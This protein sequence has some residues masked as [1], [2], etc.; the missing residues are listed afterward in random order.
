MRNIKAYN[1]ILSFALLTALLL[2][3][4]PTAFQK[5]TASI[6]L[7]TQNIS[8]R[9]E[10]ILKKMTLEEK[11]GQIIQADISAVTPEEAKEYNLGSV[12]NGGNSAPGG[13]VTAPARNWIALADEFWHASTD[14]SDGGVG[15]PLL[16]GTDA[17]HG[18]N[19]LQNATIFPHNSG[20]GAT[21]NPAL[22]RE[23]GEITAKEIRATGIDWTFAP[24]L[25]VARDD[26]W[27]RAYES[28]SENP[29]L[30]S[31]Y[32]E[33]MVEGL[34]GQYQEQNFLKDEHVIA[35][36]KHFFADGGTHQGI[37][38][39]DAQGDL[40]EIFNIHAAGYGPAISSQAQTVMASFSSINGEKMHGSKGF[41]T[42]LLRSEMGF[43][44]FVVGDWNGHG[45]VPGCSP[46]D[47]LQALHAGLD[48]FMA[49]DSWKGLYKSL[50][51]HAKSGAMDMKRLDEAVNRILEVKIR[52]GLLDSVPPSERTA[53]NPALLGHKEHRATARQAVR[54]SL[55]LLKNN[56][57][58]LPI[59]GNANILVTGS[60]AH[61]MQQQTGGWTLS[62]Q[63]DSNN[64]DAFETGE[65][66]FEGIQ[67]AAKKFGGNAFLSNDGSYTEKP[68]AAIVI[69]GEQPYAEYRGDR[70]DLV[71][72][73]KDGENLKLLKTLK[74]NG[75]P[76][77]SVF[78]TG[79]PLWVNSHI[80]ASDAF[81]VAWL[82]GT[83]AGGIADV[84]IG[85]EKA[86]PRY[87]F[88]GTLSF[89]WPNVGSGEP[90]NDA[91][92]P[93]TLFP[94]GFGLTYESSTRTAHLQED[95]GV[96]EL[97]DNFDGK[98]IT[99]GDAVAPFA[100]FLGDNSNPNTPVTSQLASSISGS[101]NVKGTDYAAQED[102]RT[103]TWNGKGEGSFSVRVDRAVNLNMLGNPETL[104]INLLARIN[105]QPIGSVYLSV[106]CGEGC[107]S[108]I[109][110][111]PMIKNIESN[112]WQTWHF[113]ISCFD[114]GKLKTDNIET[115]FSIRS[116]GPLSISVH[117]GEFISS[118][119]T[120]TC[121]STSAS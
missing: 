106:G 92:H 61:S 90:L 79:R 74:A 28:Y 1:K 56:N 27:G 30:V 11:I 7:N 82:P 4:Y 17:V 40:K 119:D 76:T 23:I 22:I 91:D 83:E 78:L 52:A 71:F 86:V 88:T 31:I 105:Q 87:N 59:A 39:G 72:E 6:P 120:L 53:T 46:T 118:N 116:T 97:G 96:V 29:A 65:T 42:D 60:G 68:D 24:T 104:A 81:V 80:N 114:L 5:S 98:L 70:S 25:A 21:K 73:F 69:F 43:E 49:P 36:A 63:G 48:M 16:W 102:A 33:A 121:P 47:C 44:G 107:S 14:K 51:A 99:R 19:N 94:Y 20:L 15:I 111:S 13:K 55:V 50:L 85:N 62:W 10:N 77:V 26:R 67:S 35:T 93:D 89:T 117:A 54:E 34:Q 2:I 115:A 18:H 8:D 101:V 84:L 100:L 103:I 110:I 57:A 45:E 37:D 32:A 109:D 66:I 9:A 3:I 75:I 108:E 41:L 38:R 112:T 64:N 58:M 95:S 12:L 113:P